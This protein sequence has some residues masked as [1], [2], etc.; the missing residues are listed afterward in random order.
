MLRKTIDL[1]QRAV[2]DAGLEPKAIDRICLVGGS[3]RIPMVRQLI[4]QAFPAPVH[5]EIDPDL[6]VALGAAVQAGLLAGLHTDRILVDVAAH[7]MGIRCAHDLGEW[8]ESDRFAV[9]VP[10][11]S[12]LPA[13]RAEEFYTMG[14]RQKSVSVPVAELQSHSKSGTARTSS[15]ACAR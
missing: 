2:R 3:T 10:R 4:E 1:A 8:V 12:V 15:G 13:N 6:C 9:I 5:E 11:N 7:S 14:D